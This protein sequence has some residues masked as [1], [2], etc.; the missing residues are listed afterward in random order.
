MALNVYTKT[1][2]D[3][4]AVANQLLQKYGKQTKEGQYPRMPDGSRMRFIPANRFLDMARK[5]IAKSLFENQI[6]FNVSH[7]RL[8]LPLYGQ[9][10]KHMRNMKGKA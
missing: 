7:I 1:P 9:L 2:D 8:P 3:A 10:I 4:R 5:A 6:N